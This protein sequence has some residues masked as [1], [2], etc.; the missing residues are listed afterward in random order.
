MR[1]VGKK[2]LG[3]GLGQKSGVL[4]LDKRGSPNWGW[5]VLG[6]TR[7]GFGYILKRKPRTTL[8]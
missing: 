3:T 1:W 5:K 8:N 4:W 7:G 6:D 2:G